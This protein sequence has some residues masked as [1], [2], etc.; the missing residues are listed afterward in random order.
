MDF[1]GKQKL[2][3]QAAGTLFTADFGTIANR[4][5]DE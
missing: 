1:S 3:I 2:E 5:V 4:M